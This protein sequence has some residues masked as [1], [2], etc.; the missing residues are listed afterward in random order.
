MPP[1]EPRVSASEGVRERESERDGDAP[2]VS[3]VLAAKGRMRFMRSSAAFMRAAATS[4]IDAVIFLMLS[5]EAM[6]ILTASKREID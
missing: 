6:R 5:T 3:S 4:F 1:I 2:A